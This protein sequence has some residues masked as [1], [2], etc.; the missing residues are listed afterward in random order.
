[1]KLVILECDRVP[2]A[3]SYIGGQYADMFVDAFTRVRPN[4]HFDIVKTRD[5]V[6]PP[7]DTDCA[8]LIT[9]SRHDA[10]DDAPWIQALRGWVVEADRAGLRVA[11]ICFGHQLIA[12]ALGGRAGRAGG[13]GIGRMPAIAVDGLPFSRADLLVSHQ[14]QV[15]DLPPG[16]ERLI[17]SEFCPN[18]GFRTRTL[19]GVQGH[20]EFKPEYSRALAEARRDSI[21]SERVDIALATLDGP[22]NA[23][24]VL[25]WLASELEQ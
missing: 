19:I 3:L 11:G 24:A 23:D 8:Y 9:G 1:M 22:L 15:L 21:G 18:F 16:S 14:D 25:G 6:L 10:F 20:P 7:L 12:H 5:G 4:W 13:W 2:D 17:S